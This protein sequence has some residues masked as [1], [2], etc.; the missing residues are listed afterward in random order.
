MITGALFD[1]DGLMFDTERIAQEGWAQ[2]A[3]Q[4]GYPITEEVSRHIVGTNQAYSRAYFFEL[5][6]DKVDYDKA[7][8]VRTDYLN[9]YIQKNG[10]PIKKGLLE[11]LTFLKEN[12]I[13][14]CVATS[15]SK[16]LAES[17]LKKA[18]VYHYFSAG[19]YGDMIQNS[20]PHPEIFLTAAG[21]LNRPPEEC[22]VLEDSKNGIKAGAAAGCRVIAVPDLIPLKEVLP[23]TSVCCSDLSEAITFIRKENNL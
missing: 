8:K 21:L 9:A 23:L 3:K 1:M 4:L 14:A 2:A 11:L 20:K 16:E 17:Y 15:T 19:V 13:P 10:V 6:G 22:A 5:F 12:H 7:R 18:G